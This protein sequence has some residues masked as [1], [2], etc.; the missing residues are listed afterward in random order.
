[1]RVA[2]ITLK[3]TP[4]RWIAFLER[5]E[6]ALRNCTAE[7]VYGI[8]GK[9]L[10]KSKIKSRLIT[11]SARQS[12]SAGA[13]GVGLSHLYCWRQC[14]NNKT[15][16]V[17]LEDDVVLAEEWQLQLE[18]LLN[19]NSGIVLLGWNFDSVLRAEFNQKQEMI[20]LFEPAHPSESELRSIL[21]S[22]EIRK[23]RQLYNAFGLPG[24]W[25]HPAMANHLLSQIR[26]LESLPLKLG[27]GLPNISCLGIDALLNLIYKEIGASVIIPPLAVALNDPLTSLTR[28]TPKEFC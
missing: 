11:H 13:I 7:Q 17:V 14:L 1:M 18:Q 19:P 12:W 16:I 4:E 20:S 27:R 24:Y 25:L 5:N 3:R 9:D 10:L 21:N 2:V 26:R 22:R 15:P 23:S 28:N 8:D 6:S